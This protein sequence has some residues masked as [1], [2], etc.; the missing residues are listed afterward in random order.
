MWCVDVLRGSMNTLMWRWG[1]MMHCCVLKSHLHTGEKS[2]W[3]DAESPFCVEDQLEVSEW[4]LPGP[5]V[6]EVTE[7]GV[8]GS[9]QPP[10]AWRREQPTH[11]MRE[12]S[13]TISGKNYFKINILSN[14][15]MSVHFTLG[16][17]SFKW[18][19]KCNLVA[20]SEKWNATD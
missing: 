16:G 19:E 7:E 4:T 9:C 1:L 6:G 12:P 3:R 15:S 20:N 11:N 18:T 13:T 17:I 10:F 14:P 8:V 2:V 5:S